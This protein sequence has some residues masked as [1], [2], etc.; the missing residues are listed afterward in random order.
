MHT[1]SLLFGLSVAA[2]GAV[3]AAIAMR[4]P[5]VDASAYLTELDVEPVHLDS[6]SERL[7]LPFFQ[8]TFGT[9]GKRV[10]TWVAGLL[11]G[12]WREGLAKRLI[13]AGV[14]ERLRPEDGGTSAAE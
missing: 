2:G 14:A 6:Y 1:L 11:P 7:T 12:N 8:R 13:L 10:A 3:A 5:A 4:R 9:A